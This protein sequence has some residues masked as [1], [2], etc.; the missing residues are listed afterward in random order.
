M[1]KKLLISL[2]PL[3]ATAALAVVPAVSQATE[4]FYLKNGVKAPAAATQVIAWGTLTLSGAAEITCKN[5]VAGNI[6][7]PASGAGT[8]S[9]AVFAT[10]GCE[11]VICTEHPGTQPGVE[12]KK[13]P[14]P[15]VL[16][17][18]EGA[19]RQ[20]STGV[21]VTVGCEAP[22]PAEHTLSGVN[23]IGENNPKAEHGT[24]ALHPGFDEFGPG[25]GELELEGS[26]GTVK[27]GTIGQL[28]DLGSKSQ[29]L[30]NVEL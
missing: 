5:A 29:E 30:I 1:S 12:A 11:S 16:E 21:D 26:G 22:P 15:N 10:Y 14:W 23:F 20:K 18:V 8:G 17:V 4:P 7:N 24:S 19:V 27:G 6:E 28:H 13:L 9:T 3:V 2:A 25:T